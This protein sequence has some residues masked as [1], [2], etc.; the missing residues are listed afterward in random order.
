M[1]SV[2]HDRKKQKTTHIPLN[3]DGGSVQVVTRKLD[4]DQISMAHTHTERH[5]R[6][7]TQFSVANSSLDDSDDICEPE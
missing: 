1:T 7:Q 6:D 4:L 2:V 5:I 3:Q